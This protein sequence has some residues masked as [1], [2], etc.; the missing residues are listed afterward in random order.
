MGG[1]P[2]VLIEALACGAPVVSTN[3]PSGP[4]EILKNGTIGSLVPVDDIE[5]MAREITNCLNS[6]L[7]SPRHEERVQTFRLDKVA[8]RY[9][10]VLIMNDVHLTHDKNFGETV[11]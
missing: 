10:E 3:C 1:C 4:R 6:A 9:M 11:F 8:D 5:A 7:I 2:N